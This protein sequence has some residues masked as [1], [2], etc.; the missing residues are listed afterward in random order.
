MSNKFALLSHVAGT[1]LVASLVFGPVKAADMMTLFT[2]PQERQLINSNRYRDDEPAEVLPVQEEVV[3]PEQAIETP[4]TEEVIKQYR[5]SG[6]TLSAEGTNMV[7]VDDVAIEEGD[8]TQDGSEVQVLT[9][10]QIRI[11][12]ITPDGGR[13]DGEI[14]DTVEVVYTVPIG[15]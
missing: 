8:K 6:I 2:T 10:Q 3:V 13:F 11:R 9:G 12:F 4:Y 14:G 1:L 15:S 5:V 7:W